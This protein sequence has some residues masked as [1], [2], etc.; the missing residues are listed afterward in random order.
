VYA[1]NADGSFL[2]HFPRRVEGWAIL[3]NPLLVD[4]DGD[5]TP[6]VIVGSSGY[7]LHAFKQDGSEPRGWPKFTGGWLFA[8]PAAAD[9]HGDG[10]TSIVAA[11]REGQLFAWSTGGRIA[12]APHPQLRGTPDRAGL[13]AEFTRKERI[14]PAAGCGGCTTTSGGVEAWLLLAL[15]LLRRM[16]R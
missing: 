12:D 10:R 4:V 16:Y 8:T 11:V 9:L 1:Y 15:L 7:Y 6:E 13:V 2:P 14:G 5:T 3:T